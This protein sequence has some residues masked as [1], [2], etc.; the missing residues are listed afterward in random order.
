MAPEAVAEGLTFASIS[1]GRVH[2]CGVTTGG[3]AYCWGRG[4]IG[5]L[6][7]GATDNHAAPV[8]VSGDL[9]FASISVGG[10]HTCGVTT[11][12]A[13]YCWGEGES[14]R[15]RPRG[16]H[17]P[18]DPRSGDRGPHLRVRQRGRCSYLRS[19]H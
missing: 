11:E 14:G 6:G 9:T 1:A 10:F 16:T 17:R 2:T 8:A 19:D 18:D 13:A 4:E 5:Q 12:G 15:T 3:A 7:N